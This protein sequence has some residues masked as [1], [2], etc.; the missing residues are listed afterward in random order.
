MS[1]S[2]TKSG[3][4]L[5]KVLDDLKRVEKSDVLVGIPAATT[6]RKGEPINNASLM[7]VLTHGS[8]LHNIPATPIV[9]PGI[10]RKRKPIA[11]ELAAASKAVLEHKPLEAEQALM[12]AGILGANGA[13][14]MFTDNDWPA[15]APSTI[16]RKGSDRRN[17]DTGSL[18]RAISWVLRIAG[19]QPVQASETASQPAATKTSPPVTTPPRSSTKGGKDTT[20]DSFSRKGIRAG[21]QR[22]RDQGRNV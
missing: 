20:W 4:G 10:E 19:K 16:R 6:S 2:Y 11:V 12:R 18:R 14:E 13:K 21:L 5:K 9:E 8:P 3:P 22:A 17:I 1:A 7:F 15:N